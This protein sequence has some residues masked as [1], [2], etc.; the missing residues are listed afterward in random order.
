MYFHYSSAGQEEVE[1]NQLARVLLQR[2]E[3]DLRSIVYRL[4]ETSTT[5]TDS[6]SNSSGSSGSSSGGTTGEEDE[7][8]TETTTVEVQDPSD[9]FTGS[10]SGLFGD[11]QTLVLH[12]SRPRL[13]MIS[14][15]SLNNQMASSRTSDLKTVSYFVAG[16]GS[17]GLQA[18]ATVH[19]SSQ[20]RPGTSGS[21]GLA[22]MEGDRL[23]LQLADKSGNVASLL[24]QT[25][26]LAPEVTGVNFRYWDGSTWA[27]QWDSA[28]Y[29]GLPR[30]VEVTLEMSFS[31]VDPNQSR[32]KKKQ[33][34]EAPRSYR[35]VI[36][37][38]ISKPIMQSTM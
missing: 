3:A 17:S 26:L 13:D 35:A 23:A 22:R 12:V 24:G 28:S 8:A 1:K 14:D 18:A 20:A 25:Q 37:L 34:V 30:A 36:A 16:S 38:P 5:S 10:S 19:F 11:T 15:P 9:A 6:S 4:E 21:Q 33:K 7:T 32:F 2:I 27:V 31:N 29:G